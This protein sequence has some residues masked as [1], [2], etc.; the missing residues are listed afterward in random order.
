MLFVC[1]ILW[2]STLIHSEEALSQNDE[3]QG[4]EKPLNPVR[5]L[6]NAQQKQAQDLLTFLT[7]QDRNKEIVQLLADE[8]QFYG[9]FL[10]E[11]TGLPQGG[12]LILHDLE[13][14]GNWPDIVAPLRET[15]PDYGWTTLSIQL[16]VYTSTPLSSIDS[17]KVEDDIS[18][19]GNEEEA[20]QTIMNTDLP[21][22]L[23][24]PDDALVVS[25]S[26]E[27]LA[28]VEDSDATLQ[29][30]NSEETSEN[31]ENNPI[32][33]PIA[34]EIEPT[35][36][37]Y[38]Q[39]MQQRILEGIKYL[40]YYGQLN[41]VIIGIGDSAIWSALHAKQ[42]Y[43]ENPTT[44]GLSV[45]LINAREHEASALSIADVLKD[46][47]IPILD[48]TTDLA[49]SNQWQINERAAN[50]KRNHLVDY[51][52]LHLNIPYQQSQPVIRRIRGWLKTHASGTEVPT[53]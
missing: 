52:H 1:F 48:I 40:Q 25:I 10:K 44:K 38:P 16:P 23:S 51:Q 21:L 43:E 11:R 6:P 50:M 47:D 39:E 24:E 53:E 17:T 27:E 20:E 3:P 45:I 19:E 35:K 5:S 29:V 42:W 14:H 37:D 13:Q 18:K 8:K 46:I 15:L 2:F 26:E 34:N 9:L 32:Q 33:S 7:N 31:D 30:T 12:I 36:G 4:N 49:N 22:P 41:M 28:D